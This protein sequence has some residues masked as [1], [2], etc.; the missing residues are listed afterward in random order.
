MTEAL[1]LASAAVANGIRRSVL[2]PHVHPGVFNNA[3][4]SLQPVFNAYRSALSNAGIPLEVRLGGEVR[5]HPY[6]FELLDAGTLPSIGWSDGQ[7]V[8]LIEFP[9]G[10]IPIGADT[11]CRAFADAGLRW[12]I[13]HPERNKEVMRDPTRI[14]PFVAA[15]CLLQ[16]TAASIIGA[17]GKPAFQTAHYLMHHGLVSVVASD[18]HNLTHRPPLM[19]QARD[20]ISA[21]YG[22]GVAIRLTE[23]TPAG[24]LDA[25]DP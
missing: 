12:M 18:S 10:Q 11:A 23:E 4:P 19:Q 14:K 2:T 16:V 3:L 25:I 24:I 8:I 22:L 9:D 21:R 17:F 13:A 7:R 6:V 1:A 15:G 5:L 20:A